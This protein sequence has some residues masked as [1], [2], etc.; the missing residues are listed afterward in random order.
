MVSQPRR[1][2][3]LVVVGLTGEMIAA[4]AT[5]RFECMRVIFDEE[6]VADV[7]VVTP[8]LLVLTNG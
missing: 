3:S 4:T 5:V 2:Q 1:P 6:S 8:F 7:I